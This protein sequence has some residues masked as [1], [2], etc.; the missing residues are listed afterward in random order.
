MN[1]PPKRRPKAYIGPVSVWV[2][3]HDLTGEPVAA[4]AWI[5]DQC[6]GEYVLDDVRVESPDDESDMR[7]REFR[8]D[9]G[10]DALDLLERL[11]RHWLGA[12][13]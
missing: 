13:A 12:A 6:I 11:I 10:Y 4:E 7:G 3:Y 8:P 9:E 5:G 1:L 2:D